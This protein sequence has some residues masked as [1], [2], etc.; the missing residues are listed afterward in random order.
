MIKSAGFYRAF[1]GTVCAVALTVAAGGAAD[2]KVRMKVQTAFNPTLSVIG[3]ASKNLVDNIE[4]IS[5][6]EIQIRY[7]EA[8]K[9]VPTFEMFDAVKSGNLDASYGWSGY[10]MGKIPELTMFAAVPL[11]RKSPRLNSS[12]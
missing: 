2:A 12:H 11:D 10:I 5:N 8:G 9:L 4:R 3:E 1:T 7:Y 6:G